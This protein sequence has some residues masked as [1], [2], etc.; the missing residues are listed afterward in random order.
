MRVLIPGIYKTSTATG[1][2]IKKNV[3]IENMQKMYKEKIELREK[4]NFLLDNIVN[5][6]LSLYPE[7]RY[8]QNLWILGIMDGRY[9][10]VSKNKSPQSI[11]SDGFYEEPYDTIRRI[12]PKIIDLINNKFPE[13]SDIGDRIKRA[14]IFTC[15]EEL[16]LV[17]KTA[18][19]KIEICS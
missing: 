9:C 14:N 5:L 16:G 3:L 17:K 11:I 1:D 2:I 4:C 7:L 6:N 8:I 12:L 15:L 10:S 13:K 19:F 18:D